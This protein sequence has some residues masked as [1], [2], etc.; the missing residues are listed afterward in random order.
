M[1]PSSRRASLRALVEGRA[2]KADDLYGRI[3]A[4]V[5]AGTFEDGPTAAQAARYGVS[6]ASVLKA[7]RKVSEEQVESPSG[8]M[9]HSIAGNTSNQRRGSLGDKQPA[10]FQ[11]VMM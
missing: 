8:S 1:L 2:S 5:Q 3:K 6:E 7:L 4:D 10:K 9:L 11:W